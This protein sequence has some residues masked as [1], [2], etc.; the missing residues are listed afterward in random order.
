LSHKLVVDLLFVFRIKKY[1]FTILPDYSRYILQS[2]VA[3]SKSDVWLVVL[4][5]SINTY[6]EDKT[7]NYVRGSRPV[8]LRY[9]YGGMCTVE[10]IQNPE[11]TVL[12]LP[13]FIITQFITTTNTI[14]PLVYREHLDNSFI[15]W[16]A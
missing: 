15:D 14:R 6:G 5:N 11:L 13:G 10:C 8:L 3:N 12:S 16:T 7:I 4:F 2:I 1:K 9:K